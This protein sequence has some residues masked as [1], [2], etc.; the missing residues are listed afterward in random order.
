MEPLHI[1]VGNLVRDVAAVIERVKTGAEVVV[2]RDAQPVVVS[3][4]LNRLAAISEC[5]ALM[6]VDYRYY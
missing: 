2:E 3:A 4:R 6:P 5:I 1:Q